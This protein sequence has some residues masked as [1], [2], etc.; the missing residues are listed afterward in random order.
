MGKTVTQTQAIRRGGVGVPINISLET[1]EKV[2]RLFH[3][4]N[5]RQIDTYEG[6]QFP[7]YELLSLKPDLSDDTGF[8]P[9]EKFGRLYTQQKRGAKI[10]IK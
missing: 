7:I 4:D 8:M 9:N 3:I 1:M 2:K 10:L 5:Q 6:D